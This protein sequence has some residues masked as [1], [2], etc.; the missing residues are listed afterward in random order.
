MVG[1]GKEIGRSRRKDSRAA[2][3]SLKIESDGF[4]GILSVDKTDF[5]E[6]ADKARNAA[7]EKQKREREVVKA[8]EE[9]EE[10]K[11]MRIARQRRYESADLLQVSI[12]QVPNEACLARVLNDNHKTIFIELKSSNLAQ[13]Q[14]Y[15]LKAEKWEPLSARP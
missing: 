11:R 12:I 5:W 1:D 13:G 3:D 8:R 7:I 15:E 4:L 9:K 14:K 2:F 10:E 6:R